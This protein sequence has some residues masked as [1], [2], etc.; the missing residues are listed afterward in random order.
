M[1]RGLRRCV[2]GLPLAADV[3]LGSVGPCSRRPVAGRGGSR[4]LSHPC[5]TWRLSR[6]WD[7]AAVQGG[8][9]L[10]GGGRPT[11]TAGQPNQ[12]QN[13]RKANR[14]QGQRKQLAKQV[15]HFRNVAKASVSLAALKTVSQQ[16]AHGTGPDR[17]SMGQTSQDWTRALKLNAPTKGEGSMLL[18]TQ[19]TG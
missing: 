8:A 5:G 16:A 17:Q 18:L 12:Q 7:P 10:A 4:D 1:V 15:Q 6:P 2:K 3:G 9:T 14:Q 13:Q 11:P 19:T